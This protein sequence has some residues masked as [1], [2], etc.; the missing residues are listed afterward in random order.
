MGAEIG[1]DTPSDCV[2]W[3]EGSEATG[4][5]WPEFSE[6][7]AGTQLGYH[8]GLFV[9]R[10]F[11]DHILLAF[12]SSGALC[13]EVSD[14]NGAPLTAGLLENV[15]GEQ[16]AEVLDPN[17]TAALS[18]IPRQRPSIRFSDD[19]PVFHLELEQLALEMVTELDHRQLR[20]FEA[21]VSGDIGLSIDLQTEALSLDLVFGAASL[22]FRDNWSK[23]A[24]PGYSKV[25]SDLAEAA[26]GTLLPEDLLPQVTLPYLLGLELDAVVWLPT[27]NDAWHGAYILLDTSNVQSIQLEGCSVDSVGCDGGTTFEFD[28]ETALGCDSG[29][30]LGCSDTGAACTTIPVPLGRILPLSVVLLGLSV[31]RRSRC[32]P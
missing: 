19:D 8:S 10:D 22:D 17:A 11:V 21:G 20:I 12:W 5:G 14:L 29:E 7:A 25:V 24:E 1:V 16:L 30:Q 23:L 4:A 15:W 32:Q 18:V 27:P 3:E 13:L 28:L 31:R 9:G 6:K 2:P 26:I